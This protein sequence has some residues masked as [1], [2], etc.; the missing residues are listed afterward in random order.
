MNKTTAWLT[1]RLDLSANHVL[2]YSL[3]FVSWM[4]TV[5]PS[6]KAGYTEVEV[7]ACVTSDE[8]TARKF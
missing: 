4:M 2:V 3:K 6:P 8:L 1:E 7:G 5:L